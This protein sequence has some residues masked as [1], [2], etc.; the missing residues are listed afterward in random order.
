VA[1][2]GMASRFLAHYRTH[3]NHTTHR[4]TITH[5][6]PE[7]HR[8]ELN[9]PKQH[10]LHER[11]QPTTPAEWFAQKFPDAARRFGCPFLEMRQTTHDGFNKITPI[12]LN[13]DFFAGSLAGDSK[14][15][16]S[17]IY[18]EPEM[19]F[20]YFEPMQQIY[21]PTSPE[22]LRNYYRA[23][24]LRCAQ[25]LN[26]DTDKLNLFAEF[27]SDKNAR[28]VTNRAKSILAASQD[29]F[30]ATSPHQR[31]RGVELHE[32][33]ARR[34]VDELLSVESGKVLML[35]DAYA[36]FCSLLKQRELEPIKRSDFKAMVGPLIRDQFNVALRNDLVVDER[37]GVRGW[38]NLRLSQTVPS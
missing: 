9:L 12:A 25:E 30:S 17:V 3:T 7:V 14:L 27:R 4:R 34:F 21:K 2:V 33:V 6:A 29:F 23:M 18:Y 26:H 31:I 35:A 13:L 19:Q 22:K 24:L 36:A 10:W 37:R 32:R 11:T 16:H 38:K 1:R 28:A 5:M 15:G 8:L 20:Y